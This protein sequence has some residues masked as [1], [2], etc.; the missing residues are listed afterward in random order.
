MNDICFLF[1]LVYLKYLLYK[2]TKI[3][4]L[5]ITTT[6]WKLFYPTHL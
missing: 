6:T 3:I 5:I 2:Q 4:I 1:V